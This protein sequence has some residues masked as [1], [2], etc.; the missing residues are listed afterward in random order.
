M[1]NIKLVE[2]LDGILFVLGIASRWRA[3]EEIGDT[4]GMLRSSRL[5]PLQMAM[6]DRSVAANVAI[7]LDIVWWVYKHGSPRR[8]PINTWNVGATTQHSMFAH[9]R[10]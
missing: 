10:A 6:T 3:R 4:I 9:I 8:L 7:N 2:L 5:L 1:V